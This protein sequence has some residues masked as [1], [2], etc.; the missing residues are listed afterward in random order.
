VE[1]IGNFSLGQD[2][3]FTLRECALIVEKTFSP[4]NAKYGFFA[5]SVFLIKINNKPGGGGRG[6]LKATFTES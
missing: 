4:K 6:N 3:V 1:K 5:H 2:G